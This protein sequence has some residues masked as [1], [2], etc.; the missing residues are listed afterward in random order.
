MNVAVAK[1]MGRGAQS[2]GPQDGTVGN[3]PQ[4]QDDGRPGQRRNL[5]LEIHIA[6]A[7]FSRRG[8]VLWWHAANGISDAAIQKLQAIVR[9]K[10]LR[11][12]GKAELVQSHVQEFA[13]EVASEWA[14]GGIGA[15]QA[16]RQSNQQQPGVSWTE[17]RHR[18]T[19]VARVMP[20]DFSQ[21]V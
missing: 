9:C 20:A 16:R 6:G 10:T 8:L 21:E 15:M 17:R 13:G 11:P 14:A 3:G 7:H 19:M 18:A 12:A 2:Q 4:R 1:R 5:L